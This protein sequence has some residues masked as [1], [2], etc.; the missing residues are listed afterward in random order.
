M[1]QDSLLSDAL[2]RDLMAV[3]QVDVFVGLPTLNN[4]STFVDVAQTVHEALA[5]YFPRDRTVLMTVDGGSTDATLALARDFVPGGAGTS[6]PSTSLRTTHR[7]TAAAHGSPGKGGALRQL[8]AAADLT[9]ARTVAVL[10]AGVTSVAPEWVAGLIAPIRN[11]QFDY[12]VPVYARH[13]LD[14]PLV[15]QLLR[16]LVRAAYGRRVQ[17]PLATEFGCSSAFLS[18]CLEQDV[19][20]TDLARHGINVWITGTA[21]SGNF[22]TAQTPVGPHRAAPG[23]LAGFQ[24]TFLQVVGSTFASLEQRAAHWLP[25]VGSEVVP[26]I[27]TLH[28]PRDAATIVD[29]R[30]LAENFATDLQNLQAVLQPILEPL[31]LSALHRVATA[32]DA[33]TYPDELWAS[34]VYEFLDAHRRSVM[35]R[36]H[37]IQALMPLYLGRTGSFLIQHAAAESASTNEALESLCLQFEQLKPSLIERWHRTSPR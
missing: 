28:E 2:L 25:R 9:Q 30:R 16:P 6:A 37:I 4:A 27:G 13:P 23:P 35:R 26:I 22:K 7:I 19:W 17:E 33:F 10:D 29:G 18:H 14:G 3:G 11:Q 36:D 24:E 12:V 15:T 34:T 31:T 21:L 1:S 20:E 8:L 32:R 5:R